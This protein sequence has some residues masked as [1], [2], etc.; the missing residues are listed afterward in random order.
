MSDTGSGEGERAPTKRSLN[1]AE[2]LAKAIQKEVDE[3]ARQHVPDARPPSPS[4][5]QRK[6]SRRP[7]I[8]KPAPE[9]G[10]H[11]KRKPSRSPRKR[12]NAP[13]TEQDSVAAQLAVKPFQGSSPGKV[14][15]VPDKLHPNAPSVVDW[16]QALAKSHL[17]ER[18]D[19]TFID[20]L[21]LARSEKLSE[22]LADLHSYI[23]GSELAEHKRRFIDALLV[24][25]GDFDA[26]K[27]LD[28]IDAGFVYCSGPFCKIADYLREKEKGAVSEDDRERIGWWGLYSVI[29][30]AMR[31][32][33]DLHMRQCA[34]P[35]CLYDSKSCG[36]KP[37]KQHLDEITA[38]QPFLGR[39]R[40]LLLMLPRES[41]LLFRGI[42][43]NVSRDYKLKTRF[44]WSPYTSTSL[45]QETAFEYM[46]GKDG[47][48]FVILSYTARNMQFVAL[49]EEAELLYGANSL[50]EVAWKLSPTL[51][52]MIGCQFDVVV[53][54]EVDKHAKSGAA[55]ELEHL[56]QIALVATE[57]AALFTSFLTR[58]VEGRVKEMR[59]GKEA[60]LLSALKEWLA[61]GTMFSSRKRRDSQHGRRRAPLCMTGGGGT[62]KTAAAIAVY[63]QLATHAAGN[64]KRILPVFVALP[65]VHEKLL[66]SRAL[67]NYV[68][69][70]YGLTP[71]GLIAM[72]E[73]FDVVLI[74]DSLDEAGLTRKEVERTVKG[75]ADG[76]LLEKQP[77]CWGCSVI[78]TTRPEYL[79]AIGV[80]AAK[81]LGPAV[82][83]INLEPFSQEDCRHYMFKVLGD[84]EAEVVE[85]KMASFERRGV[86]DTMS[87]PFLLS[88]LVEAD[89]GEDE[90]DTARL[91]RNQVY[92]KYLM[93]HA[94]VKVRQRKG[95]G[96]TAEEVLRGGE[97]VACWMASHNRWQVPLK[98]A[99]DAALKGASFSRE[100]AM[101]VLRCLPVRVEDWNDELLLLSFRHKTIPEY[102]CA[103]RLW[104]DPEHTLQYDMLRSFSKDTP[105]IRQFFR[106]SA[107]RDTAAKEHFMKEIKPVLMAEISKTRSAGAVKPVKAEEGYIAANALS[108]CSSVPFQS[109]DDLSGVR[110]AGA[111]VRQALF[112]GVKLPSAHLTDCWM[113]HAEFHDCDL[114]ECDFSG[115]ALGAVLPPIRE[116]TI[117]TC[118]CFSVA[119]DRIASGGADNVVT[120][121]DAEDGSEVGKVEGHTAAVTRI[122]FSESGLQLL[123]SSKDG[124]VRLWDVAEGTELRR[125]AHTAAV[126]DTCFSLEGLRIASSCLDKTVRV[127][128]AE[129]GQE[130]CTL[131]GHSSAVNCVAFSP[132]T[133]QPKV[134]SGSDDC[135]L[136][137]WDIRN[138]RPHRTIDAQSQVMS[139]TFLPDGARVVAGR[140]DSAISIWEVASG[141]ELIKLDAHSQRINCVTCSCDGR[142]ASCSRDKTIRIWDPTSGES[143]R[144]TGHTGDV[145]CVAFSDDGCRLVSGSADF[146]IRNWDATHD[147]SQICD[148][149][150]E[151]VCALAFSP[152]GTLLASC[153]DDCSVGLWN[154]TT[155][156]LTQKLEGHTG[157]VNDVGFHDELS[158]LASG[159]SDATIKIWDLHTGRECITIAGHAHG[160]MNVDI[161]PN[162][163]EI[164]SGSL[165]ATGRIWDVKTGEELHTLEGHTAGVAAVSYSHDGAQCATG[166]CDKRVK[167]WDAR[168]GKELHT[169]EGHTD[170]VRTVAYYPDGSRIISGGD[171]R[172]IKVWDTKTGRVLQT[173]V[174]HT[175]WVMSLCLSLDG[176]MICSGGWDGTGRVWDAQQY[177][178]LQ[179]L[180]GHAGAV[181]DTAFS[182]DCSLIATSSRD[183]TVRV[184]HRTEG[185]RF[186]LTCICGL[187]ARTTHAAPDC[188]GLTTVNPV[189]ARQVIRTR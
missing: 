151:A 139:V 131:E 152:K 41:T 25:K 96:S 81:V 62:G 12:S 64:E 56:D 49:H 85:E 182:A 133:K 70:M 39:L 94:D 28:R 141:H 61:C 175:Y 83:E 66:K 118:V 88:M 50:F 145:T 59:S 10:V 158:L 80:T 136:V 105:N 44:R 72:G 92:E 46:Q 16:L 19:G 123:S 140:K 132:E 183:A 86:G 20:A 150:T 69:E 6:P 186:V 27:V 68:M 168:T 42:T 176:S 153:S 159:S 113:E 76:S 35:K 100:E 2:S 128:D 138:R 109:G 78:L 172:E 181:T 174:G 164:I 103:R 117:F 17:D 4:S 101:E 65:T 142:V 170:E 95:A 163:K 162:G 14:H 74:L 91:D 115:A 120:I 108:L 189:E 154:A 31:V 9:G 54:R 7:T 26:M 104:R 110:I 11:T 1:N 45:Q 51:L 53:V 52:R 29:N 156:G 90:E 43:V 114:T 173:L 82:Q 30:A 93:K 166:S 180:E 63:S 130:E 147:T 119:G 15:F 3:G 149:H 97:R 102:L 144:F 98:D 161:S 146:S 73:T 126:T 122:E 38:F 55:D 5:S 116:S 58:Y 177:T 13:P 79:K 34:K 160:V 106:R 188:E 124:S 107:L 171:D 48:F 40:D 67:D 22:V 47:T 71:E 134:A 148:G 89:D 187:A 137:I 155:G 32:V 87:N 112:S 36:G 60:P 77:W 121:W 57:T 179:K 167:L 185:G 165:D 21:L 8:D 111:D 33:G 24:S 18:L 178:E 129:T 157:P 37:P 75:T 135:T 125:L 23:A 99:L 143:Q 127:W 184:W 84:V 169:L